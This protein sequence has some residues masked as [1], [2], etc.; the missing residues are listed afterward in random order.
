M[1]DDA[2]R[3]TFESPGSARWIPWAFGGSVC[4]AIAL[5][6]LTMN[7]S[8]RLPGA[9][10]VRALVLVFGVLAGVRVGVSTSGS[11]VRVS[12]GERDLRIEVGRRLDVL[13]YADVRSLDYDP[14]F[15]RYTAWIPAMVLVD[16]A[17]RR[18]RIPTLLRHGERL[19]RALVDRPE[20][21]D[22][23]PWVVIHRLERRMAAGPWVV[24]AALGLSGLIAVSAALGFLR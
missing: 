12:L 1:I 7:V 8:G 14:P 9:A 3:L 22:L 18:V 10:T 5:G 4:C 19:V 20:G 11:R 21:K 17:G 15:R 13:R 6:A 2:E 23:E 24:G 16:R